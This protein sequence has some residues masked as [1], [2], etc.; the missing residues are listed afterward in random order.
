M[1]EVSHTEYPHHPGTLY[2]CPGCEFNCYCD[3]LRSGQVDNSHPDVNC[4]N[5]TE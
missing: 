5:C 2:G 4:V 3:E 1:S